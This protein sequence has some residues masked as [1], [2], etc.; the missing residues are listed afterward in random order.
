MLVLRDEVVGR[1]EADP[2]VL[3]TQPAADPG[4][5]RVG[6]APRGS[7]RRRTGADVAGDVARRQ[8]ERAQRGD[9]QV[10][11]VLAHPGALR[12]HAHDR[13]G[14]A[15]GAGTEHEVAPDARGEVEQAREHR[16]ARR[17]TRG[18]V[19]PGCRL[20]RRHRTGE[21]EL[22][23]LAPHRRGHAPLPT[24]G[25]QRRRAAAAARPPPPPPASPQIAR[26]ADRGTASRPHCRN[27]PA[28]VTT[29]DGSG[30]A[31]MCAAS[32]RCPGRARGLRCSRWQARSTVSA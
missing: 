7:A 24:P 21:D 16:L 19:V 22:R 8:A 29:R 6:A 26:A 31:V 3:G 5:A 13:R 14:D 25:W 10:G 32:T 27:S 20:R 28:R 18:R 23:R 11:E 4:M 2:A 30:A 15:G 9:H 1:I 17:E 12:E